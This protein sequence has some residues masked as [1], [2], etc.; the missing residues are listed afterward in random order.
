MGNMGQQGT[1]TMKTKLKTIDE[2]AAEAMAEAERIASELKRARDAAAVETER[3]EAELTRAREEAGALETARF[4]ASE[5]TRKA[6]SIAARKAAN[7]A[8]TAVA[9]AEADLVATRD[10]FFETFTDED[11]AAH[12]CAAVAVRRAML[13]AE[14]RE[15]HAKREEQR[16]RDTDPKQIAE[17]ALVAEQHARE[18]AAEERMRRE[19]REQEARDAVQLARLK[20]ASEARLS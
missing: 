18:R 10:R 5:A 4:E 15:R 6:P 3:L 16:E 20:A 14:G 9:A 7:D 1:S 12:E 17:R 19:Q 2:A 8:V 11:F 13:V